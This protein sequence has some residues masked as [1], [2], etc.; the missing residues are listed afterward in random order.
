MSL[1]W[2]QP[3]H[4]RHLPRQCA[5]RSNLLPE[6]GQLLPIGQL[7][8]QQ[9]VRDL[10]ETRLLRHIMNVVTAIHQ[11]GIWI[12]PADRGFAGDHARQAR[13]VLWFVFSAHLVSFTLAAIRAWTN[14]RSPPTGQFSAFGS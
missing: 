13:A 14:Y 10:L 1:A 7:A 5:L 9:Q 3:Q 11:P 4:F 12:D 8:V 2:K 6:I